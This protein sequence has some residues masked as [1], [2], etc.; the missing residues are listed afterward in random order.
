MRNTENYGYISKI[1]KKALENSDVSIDILNNRLCR[2]EN[3]I[4]IRIEMVLR[5]LSILQREEHELSTMLN[6]K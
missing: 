5:Q 4:R 6:Y 2:I 3:K 1:F